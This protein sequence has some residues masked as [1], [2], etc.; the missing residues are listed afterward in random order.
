MKQNDN[1]RGVGSG[2][3]GK[4]GK[5]R[6]NGDWDRDGDGDGDGDG[7]ED[8]DEDEDRSVMLGGGGREE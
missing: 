1:K 8:E 7:D 6:G 2:E 4:N 3:V 5:Q